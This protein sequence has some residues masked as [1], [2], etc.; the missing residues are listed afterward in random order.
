MKEQSIMCGD[1]KLFCDKENIK[2]YVET[3]MLQ[4]RLEI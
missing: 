2:N 3:I 1:T 4:L